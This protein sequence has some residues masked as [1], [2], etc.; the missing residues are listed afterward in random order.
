MNRRNF[1]SALLSYL[2]GWALLLFPARQS[3]GAAIGDE[4]FV[5]TAIDRT[6]TVLQTVYP[7][8]AWNRAAIQKR[9]EDRAAML[10]R[11]GWEIEQRHIGIECMDEGQL[12]YFRNGRF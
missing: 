8:E 3:V 11:A 10:Q 4:V 5:V 6:G 7:F 1:V 12:A 9:A 2:W